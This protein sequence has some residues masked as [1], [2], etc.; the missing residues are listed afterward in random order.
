MKVL[1]LPRPLIS[2]HDSG[3]RPGCDVSTAHNLDT[4]GIRGQTILCL[5]WVGGCPVHCR[6]LSGI[7]GS[8]TH[9]HLPTSLLPPPHPRQLDASSMRSSLSPLVITKNVS[10]YC[11][12]S[13][14]WQ[15][16]FPIVMLKYTAYIRIWKMPFKK[17][18]H[19]VF[20]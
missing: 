14:G 10:R 5:W 2:P 11:Q 3:Y 20:T 15:N 12:M 18:F 13:P 4:T 17:I 7:P 6:M 9:P 1:S 16:Y 8:P 19:I